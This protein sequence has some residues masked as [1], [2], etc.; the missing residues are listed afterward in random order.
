MRVMISR[1]ALTCAALCLVPASMAFGQSTTNSTHRSL[2]SRAKTTTKMTN[3]DVIALASAGLDDNVI[4]AKIRSAPGTDFDTSVDG[5]KGL[6]AG[7]V[8]SPVIR[9]MIDPTSP[10]ATPAAAVSAAASPA[11]ATPAVSDPDNPESVHSPGIYMLAPMRD[12]HVH[13]TKLEHISP[14]Q[15]KTSGTWLSGATYGIAKA[16]VKVAID[17]ARAGVETT[18]TNP[19]FYAY[20]PEQADSFNGPAQNIRDFGLI[21]LDPKASTR[22]VNTATISPWGASSGEDQKAKQGFTSETV[23]PGVY[24]MTLLQPLPAGQYAFQTNNYGAFFDFGVL[25]SQ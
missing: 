3:A 2:S 5:L 17:G 9:Y 25:P 18:D 4:L 20:I 15:T 21:R 23:K 12:G 10:A 11:P 24:K 13:L 22:E 8:S 7:G 19:V 16:H 1:S 14:K 6:K